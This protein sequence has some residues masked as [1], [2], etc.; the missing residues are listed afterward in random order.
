[1]A[2]ILASGLLCGLGLPYVPPV[3]KMRIILIRTI[4]ALLFPQIT[5]RVLLRVLRFLAQYDL[6]VLPK[7]TRLMPNKPPMSA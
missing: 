7:V 3:E 2:L 6:R 4:A 5:R 1:M